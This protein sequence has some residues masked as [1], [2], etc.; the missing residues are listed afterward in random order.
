MKKE[1]K[2]KGHYTLVDTYNATD[3]YNR[4]DFELYCEAG[5]ERQRFNIE[6][7]EDWYRW[8]QEQA[9]ED[10]DCFM[11]ELKYSNLYGRAV[12]V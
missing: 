1:R 11:T 3:T 8:A 2:I 7:D 9:N 6:S 5:Y 10:Y 4:K 12:I